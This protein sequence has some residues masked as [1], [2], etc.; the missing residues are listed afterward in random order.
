MLRPAG[1][2][3]AAAFL[4][5]GPAHAASLLRVACEGADARAEVTV[6]GQFKGECPLDIQVNAGTV[7]LRVVKRLDAERERVYADDF[8]IGDGVVKKIDV[9]LS[10]PRLNAEAQRR[11]NE[12]LAR[13]RAEAQQREQARELARAAQEQLDRERV[14]VE[15]KLVEAGDA[16]AMVALA[17]RYAT[18]N[19]VA[20]NEAQ[21]KSW[22]ARALALGHPVAAFRSSV[23]RKTHGAADV[24]DLE[25]ML[26]FPIEPWRAL[27]ARDPDAVLA[28]V[29]SDPFFAVPGAGDTV[30]YTFEQRMPNGN[31]P[32]RSEMSCARVGARLFRGTSRNNYSSEGDSK[33]AFGGLLPLETMSR[34]TRLFATDTVAQRVLSLDRVAGAPFPLTPG[35][36]F[37]LAY[38]LETKAAGRTFNAPVFL[39]CGVLGDATSIPNLKNETGVPLVCLQ[40]HSTSIMFMFRSYWHERS[41]CFVTADGK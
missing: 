24:A 4:A 2:A 41:G 26:T 31:Q 19:G 6:N 14:E 20:K 38:A 13:E 35:R 40:Q 37:R 34:S 33:L 29:N 18:G 16:D 21:A 12:R 8:R 28:A 32:M 5:C 27:D 9:A 1:L 39:T 15:R 23:I 22:L 17:D 7:Q 3:A 25:R 36:Q 10:A 11:E 30:N